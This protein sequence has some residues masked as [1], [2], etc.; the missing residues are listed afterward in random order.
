MFGRDIPTGFGQNNPPVGD[1]YSRF[2]FKEE[3]QF[4]QLLKLQGQ[5]Y[6]EDEVNHLQSLLATARRRIIFDYMGDGSTRENLGFQIVGTGLANDFT[7]KGGTNAHATGESM[8]DAG[9]IYVEGYP[10]VMFD[11]GG[12]TWDDKLADQLYSALDAGRK[13]GD[14]PVTLGLGTWQDEVYIEFTVVEKDENDYADLVNPDLDQTTMRAAEIDWKVGYASND[15]TPA[16]EYDV[17]TKTW[18]Y[19]KRLAVINRTDS[20]DEIDA[21]DVVD[22]RLNRWWMEHGPNGEHLFDIAGFGFEFI[23]NI[24]RAN[25]VGLEA[26]ATTEY[27]YDANDNIDTWRITD[28]GTDSDNFRAEGSFTYDANANI[29]QAVSYMADTYGFEGGDTP[30][31]PGVGVSNRAIMVQDDYTYDGLNRITKVERTVTLT[32][33]TFFTIFV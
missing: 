9:R 11:D 17:P 23:Q 22:D 8:R 4:L 15:V 32:T 30:P 1:A 5:P 14:T 25:A 7:V 29:T 26:S 10:V 19:R 31:E 2:H 33:H 3:R 13:A 21:A 18:T 20:V 28:D 27:T 24:F 16:T 6:N 12:A